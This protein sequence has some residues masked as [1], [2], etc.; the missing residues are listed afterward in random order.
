MKPNKSFL[1]LPISYSARK[2]SL[3]IDGPGSFKAIIQEDRSLKKLYKQFGEVLL[4]FV[5]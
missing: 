3:K 4:E 5:L 1:D 2:S